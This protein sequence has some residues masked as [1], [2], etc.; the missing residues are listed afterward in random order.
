[1]GSARKPRANF[2]IRASS[3]GAANVIGNGAVGQ[4]SRAWGRWGDTVTDATEL[5]INRELVVYIPAYNCESTISEVLAA[6]PAE[7]AERAEILVIDNMSS[8][9]TST[10]VQEL[11][12]QGRVPAPTHLIR[13]NDNLGYAGSQ[14]LAYSLLREQPAVRWVMMLHGDGQYP[15][16]L[17]CDFLR[18]LDSD[19]A[20]V[21]GHRSKRHFRQLEET[22]WLTWAVIKGL[23]LCESVATGYWRREWHT[24]MIM[25]STR[26]LRKV[27]LDAL[28]ST[29]H[30]DGHLLFA[31]GYL[32]GTVAT[33]PIYK[34]YKE[35]SAFEGAARRRYVFDV[36]KL[37]FRFR[38]ERARLPKGAVDM[39]ECGYRIQYST[40]FPA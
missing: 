20:L 15:P 30:I 23:G 13:T 8:D 14:K 11:I 9:E 25:H 10:V 5:H 38:A 31:A 19:H 32:G 26:F 39:T 27:Q 21:Y 35:L 4:G 24:G 22:P 18:Y 2:E 7:V 17:T 6:I 34:K 29:P 3:L 1:M 12:R 16:Q 40:N 28:T 33:V 36:I 37:M